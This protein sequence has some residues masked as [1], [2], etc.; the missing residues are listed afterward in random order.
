[1]IR[2]L[3]VLISFAILS[4]GSLCSNGIPVQTF[5]PANSPYFVG[6]PQINIYADDFTTII[7][8]MTSNRE[9]LAR[10]FFATSYDSQFNEQK[11]IS[12]GINKSNSPKEYVFN[13]KAQNRNWQ[14]FIKQFII[15]P[16]GGPGGISVES[17]TVCESSLKTSLISGFGEFMQYERPVPR[18]INVIFG[19][20]INGVP[21]NAIIYHAILFFSFMGLLTLIFK[22]YNIDALLNGLIKYIVVICFFFW[23][24][25]DARILI[26]QI[27]FAEM[28]YQI[29]WGKSFKEKQALST[30]Q[31]FR[32]FYYFLDVCR[33]KLPY[34]AL[35]SL[36]VP[37]GYVYY[38][39]KACYYLYPC[40]MVNLDNIPD[41]I[42]V[43]DPQKLLAG[44]DVVPKGYQMFAKC[45]EA[46][47]IVKIGGKI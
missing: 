24:L 31:T 28:N 7:I 16:E 42:I 27:R 40:K 37:D 9:A 47:Y 43:Y 21:I 19:P 8:R 45:G 5:T 36:L 41:Y 35:C 13:L 25:L 14:G 23:M 39:V 11:S 32:D 12:F 10:V 1:M 6:T 3:L 26:D 18:T 2:T 4:S 17:F 44:K 38:N 33:A 15:F 34:R 22:R 20:Q 46:G 29:F 30:F